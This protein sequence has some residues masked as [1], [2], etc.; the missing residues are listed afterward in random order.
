MLQFNCFAI[1][2]LAT[3]SVV[4]TSKV[5]LFKLHGLTIEITFK[6]VQYMI[7]L[8]GFHRTI[9]YLCCLFFIYFLKDFIYSWETHTHRGRDI[10]EGEAG[11]MQGAR[12]GTGSQNSRT[13]PW[14][15]GRCSTP[16]PPR[17]PYLC[18]LK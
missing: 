5:N 10:A 12:P 11:S 3:S 9:I 6:K 18:F 8:M 14:A 7:F 1:T 13:T 16:E 15:K 2:A 17:H 4:Q